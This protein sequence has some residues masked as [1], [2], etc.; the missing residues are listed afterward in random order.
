MVKAKIT[1]GGNKRILTHLPN[2]Q[3]QYSAFFVFTIKN[4]M[5]YIFKQLSV[6]AYNST[7]KRIN[8]RA[9]SAVSAL[10]YS[11]E[12][13]AETRPGISALLFS[14]LAVVYA[15]R[16]LALSVRRR[17]VRDYRRLLC[18]GGFRLRRFG[19]F[20]VRIQRRALTHARSNHCARIRAKFLLLFN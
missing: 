3:N 16:A 12:K 14:N 15:L 9:R 18:L 19:E 20:E 11:E 1:S 17:C 7:H 8:T 6:V 10:D 5:F 2:C 4:A 13:R